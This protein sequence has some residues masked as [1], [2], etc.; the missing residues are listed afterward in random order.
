MSRTKKDFNNWIKTKK[1]STKISIGAAWGACNAMYKSRRCK[2][3]T[4]V[5][6]TEHQY[7]EEGTDYRC[8]RHKRE[9]CNTIVG[10]VEQD[11]S[12][13]KW[14]SNEGL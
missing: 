9:H 2:D 1:S 10:S 8:N 14:S 4:Y 6:K 7:T 12:C 13:I 3:C 5:V 11:F